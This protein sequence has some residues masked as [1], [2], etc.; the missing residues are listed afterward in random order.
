MGIRDRLRRMLD[1]E[2]RVDA[3][4]A[5]RGGTLGPLQ[6]NLPTDLVADAMRRSDES[7]T[8]EDPKAPR[9]P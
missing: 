6:E 9:D 4:D 1:A 3:I 2:A 5:S 8:A 7:A